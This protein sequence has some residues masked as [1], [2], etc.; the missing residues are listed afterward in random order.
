[1]QNTLDEIKELIFSTVIKD[2][3]KIPPVNDDHKSIWDTLGHMA[4]FDYFIESNLV[5]D[6]FRA[7]IELQLDK[8]SAPVKP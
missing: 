5:D 7:R 1:M 8:F 3:K 2:A 6:Y 4:N